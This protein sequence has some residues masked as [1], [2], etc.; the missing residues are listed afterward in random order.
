[1]NEDIRKYIDDTIEAKV[2]DLTD[3]R[4]WRSFDSATDI[5]SPLTAASSRLAFFG[6]ALQS[7]QTVSGSKGANA[8]LTSLLTALALYG[9]I[10]DSSS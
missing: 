6:K 5:Y 10:T 1:M 9:L 8:A 3:F 2:A 4:Q 7:K